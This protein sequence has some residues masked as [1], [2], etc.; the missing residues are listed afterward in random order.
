MRKSANADMAR[1]ENYWNWNPESLVAELDTSNDGLSSEAAHG[2]LRSSGPNVIKPHRKVTMLRSF[3]SQFMNPM[4]LILVFAALVAFMVSDWT[5][6]LIILAIVLASAILSFIQ[7][8]TA[9]QAVEKLRAQIS[10]KSKVLRD[11]KIQTIPSEQIVPGDVVLLS[12]GSLI[13]ADGIVLEAKDFFVNQAVLTGESFPVEKKPGPVA[14]ASDL[15]ERTNSIFMGTS[16]RSGSARMLVLRTGETTEFGKIAERLTLRPPESEFENGIRKFGNLLTWIIIVLVFLVFVINTV[17]AKP[18][19]ESLLF[20]IALA[21]GIAP[22]LLPAII[23][24]SLSRG[25]QKMAKRGVIV[26]HLNSIENLGS[27]DILCTDKTGTLTDGVI[28]LDAALDAGGR[29]SEEVMRWAYLNAAFQTGLANSLDEAILE[30]PHIDTTGMDKLG[31]IPYDFVRKRMSVIVDSDPGTDIEPLLLTKGA[32]E[33]VLD[34]CTGI[35]SD[36]HVQPVEPL[37]LEDINRRFSEWSAQGYRVLGFAVRNMPRKESYSVDEDE[38]EM[39]FAGFLLFF[40]PPREDAVETLASL[41]KL[42]V[43]VKIITGDN[44]LVARHVA[45]AVGLPAESILSAGALQDLHD[46]ALWNIAE[47]TSIFA[48]VDPNQKE[49]IILAL[50]KM[51]HVVGYM[52]DG[53]N[54]APALHAA[55]VGISVES[56]VDVAKEAA[57]FVLFHSDLNVLLEGIK[58]GRRTFA[59]TLKYIFTTTSANFGNMLSMAGASVFLPFLPLLAK[60]ILLNN[61]LSDFPAIGIPGDNVDEEMVS[62]PHKWDIRFIRNFMII[63]GLV[64]SAFD[65]ATFGILLLVLHATEQQFQT[66]WFIESLLTELVIA[67]VVRTRR[68]FFRSRP[69]RLLWMITLAV[70]L[71]TLA[72]PYLPISSFL[73]FVPLPL[74]VM[75]ALVIL[76]SVYVVVAELAKKS[77]YARLEKGLIGNRNRN[78][79]KA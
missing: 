15:S 63:F 13:P 55:D 61:F 2:R 7:E 52:G 23:S 16:A 36:G 76:T 3:L 47:R 75:I 49:R 18:A 48:E 9:S 42:G 65:Y 35:W 53:I 74:W 24:I 70:S 30:H 45:E 43:G 21:V 62:K 6:A 40:D 33:N 41:S 67:L 20:A 29:P 58:E 10:S 56:A 78:R 59:N 71:V 25:A 73:G 64:S 34:C 39:T 66:G 68:P 69:G 57:D 44:H 17:L 79:R 12:A 37:Q 60:Q 22:E 5:D 19:V 77:F 11:G 32:L 54:D 72:L 50:R 46:E 28:R 14:E 51:G 1:T 4:I 8:Y 38:L 31:E 26:R 27:M